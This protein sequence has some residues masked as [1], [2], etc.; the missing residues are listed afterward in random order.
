MALEILSGSGYHEPAQAAL[1]QR[2]ERNTQQEIAANFNITEEL[3]S[4]AKATGNDR[5][6][7]EQSNNRNQNRA[8]EQQIK[9]AL[10]LANNKMRNQRTRCEFSYHEETKRISI[11]VLDR[12]TE[13]VIREI[14][15]EETL[16]M[17]ERMWELAGILVDERR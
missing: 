2:T 4:T 9:N 10:S 13:E 3:G 7:G 11:K 12:D 6:S 17:L 16:D 5:T 8:S 14:P 15:Q 1:R